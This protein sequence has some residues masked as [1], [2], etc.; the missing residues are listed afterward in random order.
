MK[1]ILYFSG[2]RL[3]AYE[4]ERGKLA[5]SV[6]FE[7]DQQGFELFRRYLLSQAR[8]PVRLL[9]DIIEEEFRSEHIPHV[10]IRD[11][12]AVFERIQNKYFRMTPFRYA[13]IQGRRKAPGGRREDRA[14]FSALTNPGLFKAWLEIIVASRVPLAGIYSLAVLSERLLPAIE[15]KQGCVMLVSQQVPSN[16]RQSVFVDGKLVLSRMVPIASFF[17]GDYAGDIVHDVR[18]THRY[19]VSQHVVARS[20]ILKV[21]I[22]AGQ[23][24]LEALQS[25]CTNGDGL[26]YRLHDIAEVQRALKIETPRPSEFSAELFSGL[27]ARNLLRNHYGR[28]ADRRYWYHY[29]AGWGLVTAGVA[30]LGLGALLASAKMID[31]MLYGMYGREMQALSVRYEH[32]YRQIKAQMVDLPLDS[33]LIKASVDA[34]REIAADYRHDPEAMLRLISAD[35]VGYDDVA[36][37][38]IAWFMADSPERE[39]AGEVRWPGAEARSR[40]RPARRQNAETGLYEIAVVDAEIGSSADDYRYV[41]NLVASLERDLR[42]S[43]NYSQVQVTRRPLD[44]GSQG[45]LS[46]REDAGTEAERRAAFQLKLVRKRL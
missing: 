4:W 8:T 28:A 45:A 18:N 25:R 44:L 38:R 21:H 20:E 22:L 15:A 3:T 29:A 23:R 46:G 31:G 42:D 19:L 34:A 9:V 11:R 2:H 41:L 10:N 33:A 13:V 6:Y 7:P 16:L 26:K 43:G 32:Q 37:T 35:L 12:L 24:H 40:R 1:R 36:I 27:M 30:A 39:A 14:M 5:S 17:E